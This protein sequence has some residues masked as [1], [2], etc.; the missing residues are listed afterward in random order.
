M[1]KLFVLPPLLF[2]NKG[3]VHEASENDT[4]E[5][6]SSAKAAFPAWR[7]LD[8]SARGVYLRR[9]S[10]LIRGCHNE[11]AYIDTVNIGRPV[12]QFFL[13]ELSANLLRYYAERGWAAQGTTSLNTPGYLNMSVKQPYGVVVSMAASNLPLLALGYDVGPALAAGNTVVLKSNDYSPLSV[14]LLPYYTTVLE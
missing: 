7:D 12:K 4:N 8:P 9:L 14:S 10:D 11:L 1:S 2:A 3:P 13:S 5:A 6:V